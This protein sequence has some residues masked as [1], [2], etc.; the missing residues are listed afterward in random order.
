MAAKKSATPWGNATLLEEVS[1]RQEA[2]GREFSTHAQLLETESGER[3]VRLAYST[4]E[5][6]YV[7]RGPVTLTVEDLTRLL[8]EIDGHSELAAAFG[9]SGS[10]PRRASGRGLRRRASPG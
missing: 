6:G 4:P 3:L 10:R 8:E 9:R 5:H 7:R 2:P 1:L